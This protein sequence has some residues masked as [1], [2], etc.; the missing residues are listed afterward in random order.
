MPIEKTDIDTFLRLSK[1]FP[2]LDVRSP[3]EYAHAHI[4]A[5]FSVPLFTDEQRKVIGTAYKKQSRKIAVEIGINYFSERMKSV[6]KETLNSLEEWQKNHPEESS[7]MKSNPTFLVHCWRGGMRSETVAWLLNLYG[8]NIYVLKGGY[9]AFRRW[10]LKQLDKEYRFNILGGF[11]GSG[12]TEVLKEMKKEG[13]PVI[14]LEGLANHRGSSFG[15]LGQNPQPSQEMFENMLAIEL[16]KLQ[17][18]LKFQVA[19]E[20]SDFNEQPVIWLEDESRHIGSVG[21]PLSFWEQMRKSPVY[22]IDVPKEERLKFIVDMYGKF[23]KEKLEACILNIQKKLG[24]LETRN[25]LRFLEE[26]NERDCFEILIRYYDKLYTNGLN[27][28]KNTQAVLNKIPCKSVDQKNA[29][30]LLNC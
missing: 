19:N 15:S 5:A 22:F 14:D 10:T 9:K 25:A 13:M 24:G 29:K 27:K 26:G 7:K 3:G 23:E 20:L 18:S 17:N 21:F 12:K 8:Y 28:R 11:T 30:Y 4:P 6:Q 16:R 1:Q 2:V